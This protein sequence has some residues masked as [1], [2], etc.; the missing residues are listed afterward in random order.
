MKIP[1]IILMTGV[2]LSSCGQVETPSTSAP[3]PAV[4]QRKSDVKG[5]K[6]YK[7]IF[8]PD[9]KKGDIGHSKGVL[10]DANLA[11]NEVVIKYGVIHGIERG[12]DTAT[13]E[14]LDSADISTL[15]A[16]VEVEFLVK[17]GPDDIYRLFAICE[18]LEAGQ[19]C[20]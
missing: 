2:S 13:F 16:G 1:M 9:Y 6:D 19:S 14:R 20:L 5:P 3:T 18:I 7:A 12:A 17:K 4:S 15:Y 11:A 10:I 8:G